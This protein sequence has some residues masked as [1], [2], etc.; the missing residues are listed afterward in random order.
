ML[1]R[2]W[3]INKFLFLYC[4]VLVLIHAYFFT[5]GWN[6]MS[7]FILYLMIFIFC[8]G[9]SS[10]SLP[11]S[12]SSKTTMC[13]TTSA[14]LRKR[15]SFRD[16]TQRKSSYLWRCTR[17]FQ[18]HTRAFSASDQKNSKPFPIKRKNAKKSS[19]NFK[20]RSRKKRHRIRLWTILESNQIPNPEIQKQRIRRQWNFVRRSENIFDGK[21]KDS[22]RH[23]RAICSWLQREV[24]QKQ[25]TWHIDW[26]RRWK[27]RRRKRVIFLVSFHN[28]SSPSIDRKV[29]FDRSWLN[30]QTCLARLSRN[31]S[32]HG[33]HEKAVP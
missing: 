15:K 9:K 20:R 14:G 6:F 16:P 24:W 3:S 1:N 5:F 8:L 7:F 26:R 19:A 17:R 2:E 11:T 30:F 32:R 28:N 13:S 10:F 23:R 4:A 25:L 27:H 18:I 29:F 33:G 22:N 12:E 31:S 21:F